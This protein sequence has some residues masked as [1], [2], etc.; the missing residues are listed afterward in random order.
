MDASLRATLTL[1]SLLLS[2]LV[3]GCCV[4]AARAEEPVPTSI[5]A[6]IQG[7][8][9]SE[10]DRRLTYLEERLDAH[11][12]YAWWWWSGWTAF[13]SIG[14][15]VEGVRAGLANGGATRA[16]EIIGAVKATGGALYLLLY[17]LHAKDGA[18]AVRALPGTTSDDRRR[19]LVVAEEQLQTNADE[20]HLRYSWVRHALI[21]GINA[22]GAVIVWKGFDDV[23]R[24][25]RSAGIG[26]AVG[27]ISLWSR[28]W[29]A[30]E[31]W[32]EYQHRFEPGDQRISW[33]IVPTVGGAALQVTF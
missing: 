18:D 7:M 9:D 3:L 13:Y 15:G 10:V 4:E 6:R 30:A 17:P 20:S 16:D 1:R 24:G 2:A 26:T 33:H 19:Q 29:W 14:A 21:I 31:D 11:R 8:S 27:E 12:D 23:S 22:V 32:E 25:W 5:P 28:P